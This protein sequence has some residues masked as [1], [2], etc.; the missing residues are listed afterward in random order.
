MNRV[1]WSI[2]VSMLTVMGYFAYAVH[3]FAGL[4]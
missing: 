2:V 1:E 4:P 3:R